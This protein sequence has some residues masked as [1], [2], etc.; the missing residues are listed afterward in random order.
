MNMIAHAR[1]ELSASFSGA[2]FFLAFLLIYP[3][4]ISKNGFNT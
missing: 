2:D 3:S 1:P 4:L